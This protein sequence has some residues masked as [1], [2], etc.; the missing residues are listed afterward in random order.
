MRTES[1]MACSVGK[2]NFQLF[3]ELKVMNI[4]RTLLLLVLTDLLMFL[5][6]PALARNQI[7]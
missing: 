6:L 4:S 1:K 2:Q 5:F 3:A 7:I